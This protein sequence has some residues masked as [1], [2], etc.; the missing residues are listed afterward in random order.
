MIPVV[1]TPEGECVQDSS[2][3][4]D[5]LEA[6]HPEIP[7][8]SPDPVLKLLGRRTSTRRA[9]RTWPPSAVL[10]AVYGGPFSM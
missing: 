10:L 2:L 8:E 9:D 5:L 3:I 6:R 7:V 4:I 1:F